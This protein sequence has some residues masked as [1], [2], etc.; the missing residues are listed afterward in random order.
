MLQRQSQW[1]RASAASYRLTPQEAETLYNDAPL[2]SLMAAAH[3]R[4][5]VMHPSGQVTY[6]VDRNI[7]YTNVCT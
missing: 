5:L 6:L 4:R 1:T 3:Q 7:N 2:H